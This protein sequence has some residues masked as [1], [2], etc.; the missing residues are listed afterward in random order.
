MKR[1]V[2]LTFANFLKQKQND[3]SNKKNSGV[4]H[5]TYPGA[6]GRKSDSDHIALTEIRIKFYSSSTDLSRVLNQLR[7]LSLYEITIA[8]TAH[9]FVVYQISSTPLCRYC[10]A[11]PGD[12]V[13]MQIII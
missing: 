5:R 1:T 3:H 4:F 13:K 11:L 10:S 7:C 6:R 9:S 2:L 12:L 8:T